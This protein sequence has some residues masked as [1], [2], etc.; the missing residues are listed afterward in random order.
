MSTNVDLPPARAPM[1]GSDGLPTTVY[2]RFFSFLWR[3]TGGPIDVIDED[4]IGVA[5][6]YVAVAVSRLSSRVAELEA[7]LRSLESEQVIRSRQS[8][9]V[10][11]LEA[12]IKSLETE[13]DI[14]G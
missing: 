3:R 11:A 14:R 10:S 9:Q 1:I 5:D 4:N 7:R 8:A 2:Y 13:Q 6:L 12:R